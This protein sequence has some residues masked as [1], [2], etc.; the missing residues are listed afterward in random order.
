[1][2]ASP[3]IV[4]IPRNAAHHIQKIAPGPPMAIAVAA[5]AMLPVPTWAAIAVASA[6]NDDIPS[7]SALSFFPKSPPNIILRP[8]NTPLTWMNP[9]LLENQIPPP[10]RAM[11]RM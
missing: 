8:V 7:L 4:A 9:N 1:M 3:K 6:W 2:V 5:P 10:T 11:I